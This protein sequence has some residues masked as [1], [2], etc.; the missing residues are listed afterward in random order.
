LHRC[1]DNRAGKQHGQIRQERSCE[2]PK[3]TEMEA[4]I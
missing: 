3:A 1:R 2:C 4:A